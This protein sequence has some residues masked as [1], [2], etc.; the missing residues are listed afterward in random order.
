MLAISMKTVQGKYD[1]ITP[2]IQQAY[3]L[4]F[5]MLETVAYVSGSI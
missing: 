1:P 5:F 3:T 4:E 2:S